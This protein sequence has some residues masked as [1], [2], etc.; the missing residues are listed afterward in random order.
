MDNLILCKIAYELDPH[1]ENEHNHLRTI[2]WGGK[3]WRKLFPIPSENLF[4]ILTNM[5]PEKKCWPSKVI[6]TEVITD[7]KLSKRFL[8]LTYTQNQGTPEK[9][10]LSWQAR[11][12]LPLIFSNYS[13]PIGQNRSTNAEYDSKRNLVQEYVTTALYDAL[14]QKHQECEAAATTTKQLA[15]LPPLPECFRPTLCNYQV[16]TVNWLL[17]REQH[18]ASFPNYYIPLQAKDGETC[19]YKHLFTWHIEGD[20]PKEIVLAPGGILA[21]EMGLGKTVEMLALIVLNKRKY[22]MTK[23]SSSQENFDEPM[24]KCPRLDNKLFCIC[25]SKTKTNLV[26][27]DRC[28]LK[29]HVKCVKRFDEKKGKEETVYEEDYL[30]PQC[31][32][33]ITQNE[34]L[35]AATTFIVT[36]NTIKTQWITEIQRH[37]KPT[38]K[39]FDY[40]EN[41]AANWI[42]PRQLASYDIVITDY[43]VLRKEI[44]HTSAYL[45][46]RVT[47]N[48]K[49]SM[50]R[51]SPLLM[52]QWWRVCLDEAQMVETNTTHV[53]TMVRKLPAINRW[54]VTGTPIQRSID[55]LRGLLE[56]IGFHEPL[57]PLSGWNSLMEDFL[58][59]QNATNTS[60]RKHDLTLVDVLQRC[61]W[62]TCKSKVYDEL[63]IPPQI[64]QV[65]RIKLSNLEKLFYSEQ[66][67]LC[68]T[69]FHTVLRKHTKH[70]EGI[71][72]ISPK[73]MNVI[74]HPLLKIRQCCTIPVVNAG[75]RMQNRNTA[76]VQQKLFLQPK[77]L[78]AH[79]KSTNEIECKSELRTMASSY[80]GMAAIYFIRC[81]YDEAIKN[82]EMVLRLA[83]DYKDINI[84]VDSLLQIHALHNI[85]QAV[86]TCPSNRQVQRTSPEVIAKY[87]KECNSL[88]WKYLE[89]YASTMHTMQVHCTSAQEMLSSLEVALSQPLLEFIDGIAD[90][91]V[92]QKDQFSITLLKR[93][94]DEFSTLFVGSPKMEELRSVSGMLYVLYIWY[95]KVD[96]AQKHLNEEFDK[97]KFYTMNVNTNAKT[98]PAIWREM[99]QFINTVFDCHLSEILNDKRDQE[100]EKSKSKKSKRS[101]CKLCQIRNALNDFE[102]LLFN[103]VVDETTN[104]T[105][106]LENP[107][108]E[109]AL[110]RVLFNF[111]RTKTAFVRFSQQF[112]KHWEAIECRQQLCKKLIKYWIEIE[113]TVK[114]YDE[115]DMCKMRISLAA[116]EEEKTHFKLLDYELDNSFVEHQINLHN[117]QRKFAM[118]L[119]RLKY[120]THLE[121]NAA[122]NQCP[123][124]QSDEE[125][126]YA[127]LECGHNICFEC[128]RTIRKHKGNQKLCCP[129]CRNEQSSEKI[130]YV[131]RNTLSEAETHIEIKGEYSS[132]ISCIVRLVLKL[133]HDHAADVQPIKILIF[134][135]W[136]EILNPIATALTQNSIRHR[137]N[138]TPRTIEEFKSPKLGITCLLMPL[139]KG[140]NGLNLIEA[141]HVFLVEP[142][143]NPGEEAQA[144]GRVHRFGQTKSTTVHRFIVCNTIE[145]NIFNVVNAGKQSQANWEFKQM[146]VESL[147]GLFRLENDVSEDYIRT[148]NAPMD[149]T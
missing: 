29:Q 36:P 142:I 5:R 118:K 124:C 90:E 136:S 130:Y 52:I 56:F 76:A 48:E 87:E 115:L 107:S 13:Q 46:E 16:R 91:I 25:T 80:N 7:A 133:Q 97:L 110:V 9:I 103:K 1:E 43:S 123:I 86:Y 79:L 8:A 26:Q 119:A 49:R 129:V 51:M 18:V 11:S 6:A 94:H 101:L 27:C 19:V 135:Q 24:K 81:N 67:A 58:M 75:L 132:K 17:Q 62:R 148:A 114:A 104:M 68:E 138:L 63:P 10:T 106:G 77:D 145:E 33:K 31:W 15:Q 105:D 54:A 21:D 39:V 120:I 38:L 30:C 55:D 147:E 53:G 59:Q 20:E 44:Y 72:K 23:F 84:T 2:H 74:L 65:H 41:A 61:M 116:N 28:T 47:R 71:L 113:Y 139:R 98:T 102:C 12:S 140:C 40:N 121:E 93:F 100:N 57:T 128:L 37:I 69:S 14:Y 34:L 32:Y 66:H 131:T 117:A 4:C 64:E 125:Y 22:T 134:S 99:K 149:I 3:Q 126:R 83:R 109:V 108:F 143:L 111:L 60:D 73:I 82:Y 50:R 85:Q 112:D 92:N 146:S 96:T 127:V 89:P 141:T 137:L 35:P 122:T 45:S 70:A 144:I 78:H 88:E 42:N 95:Q